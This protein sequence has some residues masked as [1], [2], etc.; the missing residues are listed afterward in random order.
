MA[1]S[2]T[3]NVS[4]GRRLLRRLRRSVENAQA[5][6]MARRILQGPFR[7]V[8]VCGQKRAGNHV[9]LNWYM[10]QCPGVRLHYNHVAPDQYPTER[11]SRA[12]RT[13]ATHGKDRPPPTLVLS[14]EDRDLQAVFDGAL[15]T[16][17]DA[18]AERITERHLVIVARDPRNLL[19]SRF[20][21]WPEEHR[22]SERLSRVLARFSDYAELVL[23]PPNELHGMRFTAVLFDC[24]IASRSYRDGLSK[25]LEIGHGDR[26][27]DEVTT[28]GHGSSFDGVPP[29]GQAKSMAVR[30]RWK[31]YAKDPVFRAVFEAP[32]MNGL[33][34]AF[35]RTVARHREDDA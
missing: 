14:Y 10:S 23:S 13:G 26:G 30:D 16:F 12:V 3:A 34:D 20:R 33:Q 6:W 29:K 17:L 28:H 9:F 7:L 24:L 11:H 4:K 1:H 15:Q 2:Q 25:R 22:D 18:H 27:L 19:A 5:D 32:H 31:I 8:V 21:K 35:E